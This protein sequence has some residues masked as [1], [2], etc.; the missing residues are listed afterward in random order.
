MGSPQRVGESGN[1]PISFSLA[2]VGSFASRVVSMATANTLRK[3]LDGQTSGDQRYPDEASWEK[4]GHR[5]GPT[6]ASP[7]D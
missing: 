6:L 3:V 4:P 7:G 5:E 2:H 1:L